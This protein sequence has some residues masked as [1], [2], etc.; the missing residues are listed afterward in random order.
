[1]KSH[2]KVK[3]RIRR[4]TILFLILT[5]TGNAFAWF[6]YNNRVQTNIVAG[7]KSWKISF[8]QNG[9]NLM[10]EAVF[11]VNKIYPGMTTYTDQVTISNSGDVQAQIEY[12]ITR[13]KIFGDVYTS[14]SYTSTQLENKLLNDYPFTISF[15]VQ[16]G[17]INPSQGTNFVFTITWPYESGDDATDTYW[18]K[19]AYEFENNHPNENEIEITVIISA[20]QVE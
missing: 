5:M 14:N 19:R 18:G 20:T 8:Q 12:E 6:I 9:S 7:V 13:V 17:V 2:K 16:S 3:R 4:R 11:N 10:N 1:M 15:N